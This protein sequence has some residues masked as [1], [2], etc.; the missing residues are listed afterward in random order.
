MVLDPGFPGFDQGIENG[1]QFAQGCDE[2]DL[3]GFA[4]RTQVPVK[5][6]DHKVVAGSS[7][8]GH[9]KGSAHLCAASPHGALASELATVSVERSGADEGR[10]LVAVQL[11]QLREFGQE[12]AGQDRTHTRHALQ[13][14]I[15]LLP[16]RDGPG[17]GAAAAGPPVPVPPAAT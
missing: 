16:G 10:D 7:Q 1:E 12:H 11:T 13:Q 4:Q 8:G 5:L 6:A 2:G 17:A 15:L 9:V 14:G 3:F